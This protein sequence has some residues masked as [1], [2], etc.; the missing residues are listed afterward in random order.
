MFCNIL[1]FVTIWGWIQNP[2]V[3]NLAMGSDRM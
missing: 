3:D 1:H 2:V